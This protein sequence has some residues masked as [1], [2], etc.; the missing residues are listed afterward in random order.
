MVKTIRFSPTE[1][2]RI[3]EYLRQN[4][5][6]ESVS[7]LGRVAVMEF[8]HSRQALALHPLQRTDATARPSFLWDYAMT[9]PQ[10]QELL[11]H[12]P[13]DQKKWLIARILEKVPLPEVL[14]FLTL[15]Q[16]DQALPH[17]R[18]NPKV[19][20]HWQEALLLWKS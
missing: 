18:L 2:G 5:A 10:A 11:R 12:A 6:L 3:K 15:E 4:P 9:E 19:K 13:M 1:W 8:M 7:M 14:R 17:V 20:K 16:I